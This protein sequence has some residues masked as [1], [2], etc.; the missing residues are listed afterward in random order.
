[1]ALRSP[2]VKE[3][4]FELP[5]DDVMK[6]VRY[7]DTSS[8]P[9]GSAPERA[10]PLIDAQAIRQMM[11]PPKERVAIIGRFIPLGVPRDKPGSRHTLL[12]TRKPADSKFK[13]SEA[14]FKV[15]GYLSYQYLMCGPTVVGLVFTT[16]NL[17]TESSYYK[18]VVK[19]SSKPVNFFPN[20]NLEKMGLFMFVADDSSAIVTSGEVESSLVVRSD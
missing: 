6:P 11:A 3:A 19:A 12:F 15:S 4:Q 8:Q 1:M 10:D 17:R 18:L 13:L 14:T 2:I 9:D 20:F 16:D 5:F 7:E